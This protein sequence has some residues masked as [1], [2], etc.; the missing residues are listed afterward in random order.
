MTSVQFPLTIQ[1]LEIEPFDLVCSI[2]TFIRSVGSLETS[3]SKSTTGPFCL[4]REMVQYLGSCEEKCLEYLVW[5]DKSSL[6]TRISELQLNNN[7]LLSLK[8]N[9]KTYSSNSVN[10][11]LVFPVYEDLLFASSLNPNSTFNSIFEPNN[12]NAN[13]INGLKHN[14]IVTRVVCSPNNTTDSLPGSSKRIQVRYL[15][16]RVFM[17]FD[18][19]FFCSRF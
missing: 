8:S 16:N 15:K 19:L 14:Q 12:Q 10:S 6:W 4:E 18:F 17:K 3:T 2:E 1:K 13:G 11:R 7:Y 5:K 9:E